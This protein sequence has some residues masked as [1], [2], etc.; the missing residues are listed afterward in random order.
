MKVR[1][2]QEVVELI[3]SVGTA[4]LDEFAVVIVVPR[5]ERELATI[6]LDTPD[7]RRHELD[8]A[9]AASLAKHLAASPAALERVLQQLEREDEDE[10]D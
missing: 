6:A 5:G 7:G 2:E 3:G 4:G 10:D 1:F 9:I 8:P